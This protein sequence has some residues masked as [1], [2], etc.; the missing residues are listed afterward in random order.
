MNVLSHW[1]RGWINKDTCGWGSSVKFQDMARRHSCW[2]LQTTVSEVPNWTTKSWMANV[3][4]QPRRSVAPT[5]VATE[6]VV[7]MKVHQEVL[8]VPRKLSGSGDGG[9]LAW[10]PFP[11]L[12]SC[13]SCSL[14]PGPL[15]S[16]KVVP[17]PPPFLSPSPVTPFSS[18]LAHC[19]GLLCSLFSWQLRYKLYL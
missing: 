17:H 1:K 18:P 5:E 10:T 16:S 2:K 7:V 4:L 11:S 6:D 15:T 14:I 8:P 19:L 12:W 13:R 9:G 3:A